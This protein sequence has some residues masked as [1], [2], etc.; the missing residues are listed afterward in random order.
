MATMPRSN[1]AATAAT[2]TSVEG[3]ALPA[4]SAI[5]NPPAT[6]TMQVGSGAFTETALLDAVDT[7]HP[8]VEGHPRANTTAVQNGVDWNDPLGRTPEDPKF[9]GQ[10]LDRSVYGADAK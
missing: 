4:S 6:E 2:D 8:S 5:A 3:T 10:G 7:S 1:P 9:V